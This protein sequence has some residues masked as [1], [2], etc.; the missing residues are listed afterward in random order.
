MTE[1]KTLREA[2]KLGIKYGVKSIK[3]NE[4]QIEFHHKDP[5]KKRKV[6]KLDFP[7]IAPHLSGAIPD[8]SEEERE[9]TEDE[10]LMYSSPAYD[11]IRTQRKDAEKGE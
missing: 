1:S 10:L 6:S 3:T 7:E 9:P 2:L 5:K 8:D 11:L 4:F